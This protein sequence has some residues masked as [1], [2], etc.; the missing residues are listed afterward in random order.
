[1]VY[2]DN[3]ATTFPKPARVCDEMCRCMR[4]YCG[5]PGRGAHP[6]AM[7]AAG[8]VF[9]C[10]ER[11][12]SFFGAP[13]AD[14]V[15]MTPNATAA[16]NLAI[17]GLV[18]ADAC[19]RG[20]ERIHLIISDLEHNSVLRPVERL[21]RDG[22]ADYSVFPTGAERGG[23]GAEEILA[24]ISRLICRRTRAVICTAASNICSVRL[25]LREIGAM[26]RGRGI[27]F[28]VD[29]AQGAGHFLINVANMC[30]DALAL[31]GHKG[32][33]GPQGSG[34]LILGGRYLPVPLLEGGSGSM[35]FDTEM[36]PEPPEPPLDMRRIIHIQNTMSSTSGPYDQNRW[37][38]LLFPFSYFT[39]PLNTPE[40]FQASTSL[41][42]R[43]ADGML[44]IT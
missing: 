2:L 29:G 42:Q 16:L 9:E 41:A 44:A 4:G 25:P 20:Q 15:I 18:S 34:A 19:A 27:L 40:A 10:R 1:M 36:P 11:L 8:K 12:A 33:Y 26:C 21:L 28:I 7:A 32:L 14:H 17:K 35:S 31:P 30:I 37:P 39:S 13:G 22:L 43:S 3:A 6:I 24:G 23:A 5:N 38:Q